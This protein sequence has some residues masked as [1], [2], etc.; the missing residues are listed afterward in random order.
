M[1][2]N[3]ERSCKFSLLHFACDG[4]LVD[5]VTTLLR[6]GIVRDSLDSNNKTP[7][8]CFTGIYCR[9]EK[10]YVCCVV[11]SL[12]NDSVSQ[13]MAMEGMTKR[14]ALAGTA[15]GRDKDELLRRSTRCHG[16]TCALVQEKPDVTAEREAH[17]TRLA[18][19][20][21]GQQLPWAGQQAGFP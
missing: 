10:V 21:P 9:G 20:W 19:E 3:P 4:G 15:T 11:L 2:T 17:A 13:D 8:V 14:L 6:L 16:C 12:S 5:A 7:Q 18:T 1:Y